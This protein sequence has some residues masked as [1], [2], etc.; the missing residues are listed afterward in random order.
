MSTFHLAQPSERDACA[1]LQRVFG[2]VSAQEKWTHACRDAR[3]VP[4]H[5]QTTAQLGRVAAELARQG[6]ATAS[7]ARSIEI[8]LHTFSRYIANTSTVSVTP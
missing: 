5:V 2:A 3:L 1:A 6:G 7:V 8:R 4:G